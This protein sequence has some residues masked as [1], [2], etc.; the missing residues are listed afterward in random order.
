MNDGA[1]LEANKDG[2]SKKGEK[3]AL[4]TPDNR[5][6]LSL[7]QE[8]YIQKITSS[9]SKRNSSSNPLPLWH[10]PQLEFAFDGST[11]KCP[12]VDAFY[13]KPVFLCAPHYEPQTSLYS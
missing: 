6:K 12:D 1:D 3:A 11:D 4:E 2:Q 5:G 9:T 7:H 10:R 8:R 13:V